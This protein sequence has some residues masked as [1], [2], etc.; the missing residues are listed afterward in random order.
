MKPF[1]RLIAIWPLLL[2]AL[3]SLQAQELPESL[4]NLPPEQAGQILAEHARA[5]TPVEPV[6]LK[7]KLRIRRGSSETLVPLTFRIQPG[8]DCWQTIYET[9]P[10]EGIKPERLV[11]NHKAGK[12]NEYL[13]SRP[14][15]EPV[16]LTPAEAFI[17]LAT[18]DFWLIDLGLDFF[19]WPTQRVL[20]G[21]M[22]L[23]RYTYVLESRLEKPPPTGYSKVVSWIDKE[24]TGPIAAE[25]YDAKGKLL[26]E[27][28]V[29]RFKK[30]EGQWQLREMEIRNAQSKSTTRIEFEFDEG[31]ASVK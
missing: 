27:F 8:A 13:Y 1:G 11:V 24:T 7:G 25:A 10:A 29:R 23:N 26:K 6:E 9:G 12:P 31:N 15:K 28:F 16:P 21:Q 17:P 22:R 14:E 5:G 30:F 19:H 2:M 20:R 18:S 4:L 3:F